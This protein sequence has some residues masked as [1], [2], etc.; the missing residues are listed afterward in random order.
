MWVLPLFKTY[1]WKPPTTI[2]GLS[3]VKTKQDFTS[4]MNCGCWYKIYIINNFCFPPIGVPEM[5]RSWEA[6][7]D[8]LLTDIKVPST[9]LSFQFSVKNRYFRI[10]SQFEIES[11]PQLVCIKRLQGNIPKKV[12]MLISGWWDNG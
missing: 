6:S 8:L 12:N 10:Q 9:A 3:N 5:D 11:K 1:A 4:A 2:C 7:R